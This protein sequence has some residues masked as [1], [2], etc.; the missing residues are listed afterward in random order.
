MMPAKVL[1]LLAWVVYALNFIWVS[2]TQRFEETEIVPGN[3]CCPPS[4][5]QGHLPS[6]LEDL[7]WEMLAAQ[8]LSSSSD[9]FKA[10]RAY[11]F[12]LLGDSLG[13]RVALKAISLLVFVVAVVPDRRKGIF[14]NADLLQKI[15]F[16]FSSLFSQWEDA[17][18]ERF[19]ITQ[20]KKTIVTR[21]TFNT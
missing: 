9:C 5:L 4:H 1:F 10:L 7:W 8:G 13:L 12:T 16:S 17:F 6:F 19:R 2:E 11:L 14:K 20:M 15:L 18:T 3:P 21:I